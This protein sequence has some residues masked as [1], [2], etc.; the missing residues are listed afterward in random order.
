MKINIEEIEEY[1]EKNPQMSLAPSNH[2][3]YVVKGNIKLDIRNDMYGNIQ[4]E[5][6]IKMV[7]PKSFP[8]EIP[9]VYELGDRFPKTVDYHTFPSDLSLC[10]GSPMSLM[11]QI[12][13][14]PTL[15]GFVQNCIVPYLYAIS[16]KL[17]KGKEFVFGELDHGLIGIL[18]NYI[19]VF[20]LQNIEQV[21]QLLDIL[22]EKPNK[23]NK[24]ICPCGCNRIVTRCSMHKKII[25]YRDVIP[26]KV[27]QVD[28][29]CFSI[30]YESW[31]K[32]QK[33]KRMK[34]LIPYA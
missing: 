15:D 21:I 22:S 17:Q 34:R 5:F 32:D 23:G 25:E 30:L 14:N 13:D 1:L 18:Q 28:K 27:Y 4:D 8:K 12:K 16:L 26:R 19:E 7:I 33:K 10:L 31:K 3:E 9:T 2:E 11:K 6:L 29:E 20:S 24:M